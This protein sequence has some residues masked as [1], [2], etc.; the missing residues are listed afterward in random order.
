MAANTLKP[1]TPRIYHRQGAPFAC[2][3]IETPR[4]TRPEDTGDV[5]DT[6]GNYAAG[7][8]QGGCSYAPGPMGNSLSFDGTTGYVQL[9]NLGLAYNQPFSIAWRGYALASINFL[10]TFVGIGNGGYGCQI[11]YDYPS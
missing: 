1:S 2:Y 6:A 4:R 5:G 7:I 10:Q 9:P 8:R 11:I 3:L